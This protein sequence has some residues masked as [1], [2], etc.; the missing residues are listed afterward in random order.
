MTD[1]AV[2][3]S[4]EQGSEGAAPEFEVVVIGSGVSGIYQIKR[5]ADL[6]VNAVVLSSD[7]GLGGTW[8]NNRYPG[9]RFDSESYTYGYSFSKE[10][11]DEWHW[12]ERF[13]AQPE[14]LRYLNYIA[15]KFD[16]RRFMRF[17]H[18]VE[19]MTFDEAGN[20]WRI[21]VKKNGEDSEEITTRF[22]IAALGLLSVPTLP[23]YPGM[24]SFRGPSFHTFAWPHEPI[25]LA[26]KRVGVIGTGA[27]GIQVI[28]DIADQVGHLTVFQRRPNWSAP[29][30]NSEISDEE[31][32]EIRARYEQIFS[33][34]ARTPGGFEHEPD[35]RGFYNLTKEERIAFWDSLYGTPGFAV[36]LRN[37]VEIFVDEEANAEFSEYIANRIRERV[38][39]PEVAEKLIPKDHG[40]GVQRVP[41]ETRYFEVYN[42]DNV[43]LVDIAETPIEEITP[44]GVRTSA[45]EIELDV[46]VYATGFD[47]ITGAFDRIDI[48]GVGGQKLRDKWQD[49]PSTY[50]GALIH[51]FPNLAM[52][53]G[54][55]SASASVNFPRSIETAVDWVTEF[56]EFV[57]A[58][59][60]QRFEATADAE[61]QW[62]EH[63]RQM[64][65]SMLMRNAKSWFTGYNSNVEGHEHG[66]VRYFV[67]NGGQPKFNN[68]LRDVAANGYEGV[69]FA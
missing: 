47:A 40:F 10:V 14:N 21:R 52:I 31:M 32:A 27:T 60:H 20:L 3:E 55:Q 8:Y 22:V 53:A 6:G 4:T 58:H 38:K 28:A 51:G 12:K 37:F 41:M 18:T 2:L 66:K 5:L 30:A 36:W 46:I 23:R 26:G 19:S 62:T 50:L 42:R 15:D 25:D 48:T 43:D 39:N 29:L 11:L 57:R 35:R 63:V 54:P 17:N 33:T 65:S 13:S 7:A 34:C 9:S 67:Y 64:Y 44:T 1:Q 56:Y 59:G 68:R 61:A 16:L 45:G 49:G 24:D 69:T